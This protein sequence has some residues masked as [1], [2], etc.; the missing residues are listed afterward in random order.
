MIITE[1]NEDGDPR[2]KDRSKKGPYQ[3][4]V[5]GEP[6]FGKDIR[7]ERTKS[8]PQKGFLGA[9]LGKQS[10]GNNDPNS[11]FHSQGSRQRSRS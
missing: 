6:V 10:L 3:I 4:N 5:V 2:Q 1:E 11:S 8:S 7:Q 9:E